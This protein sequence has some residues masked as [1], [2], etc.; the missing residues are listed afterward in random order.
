MQ[1]GQSIVTGADIA[2]ARRLGQLTRIIAD[3]NNASPDEIIWRDAFCHECEGNECVQGTAFQL[4][5]KIDRLNWDIENLTLSN[6][7]CPECADYQPPSSDADIR[8]DL[9]YDEWKDA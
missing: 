8:A 6:L 2:Q 4:A 7:I 5:Q 3:L 1:P 9:A